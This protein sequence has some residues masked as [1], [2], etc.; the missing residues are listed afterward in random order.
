MAQTVQG[1]FGGLRDA[2]AAVLPNRERWFRVHVERVDALMREIFDDYVEGFDRAAR[3][4]QSR[5]G[6]EDAIHVLQERRTRRLRSRLNLKAIVGAAEQ[7]SALAPDEVVARVFIEVLGRA[8][9]LLHA[10]T[11][12][13]SRTWY[14]YYI[15][16]FEALRRR[17]Q[18]PRERSNYDIAGDHDLLAPMGR[19]LSSTAHEVLPARWTDYAASLEQ[20]RSL[21][22]AA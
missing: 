7:Q 13:L 1:L 12:C 14:S 15:E 22:L 21:C 6:L 20:L 4:C 5:E 3:A 19:V 16:Q 10:P 8:A 9:D 11:D 17:G 2:S 18:D